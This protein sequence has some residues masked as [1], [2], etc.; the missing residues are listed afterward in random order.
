M[1]ANE[2]LRILRRRATRLKIEHTERAAGGSHMVV[3]HG[4]RRTTIA[5]HRGDMKT[6]TYR[7]ILKQLGLTIEDLED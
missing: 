7:A 3:T 4:G 5:M 1:R 2:L 6:G